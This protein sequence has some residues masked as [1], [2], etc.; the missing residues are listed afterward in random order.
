M[1]AACPAAVVAKLLSALAGHGRA[2]LVP[3]DPILALGALFELGA[4]HKVDKLIVIWIVAVGN[5]I[6]GATHSF[7]IVAS[8]GQAIVLLAGRAA[9]VFEHFVELKHSGAASCRTP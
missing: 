1:W 6:F 3:F 8:A 9:V 2:S 7:V 5:S 4:L